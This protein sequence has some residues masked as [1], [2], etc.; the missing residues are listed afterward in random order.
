MPTMRRILLLLSVAIATTACGVVPFLPR[1][2]PIG[3]V[4]PG[5]APP[6]GGHGI[7]EGVTLADEG[8]T[9]V[10]EF[11]GGPPFDP[12]DPCSTAYVGWAAPDDADPG[13][14]HALVIDVTP[15]QVIP[16]GMGCDAV[17]HRRFVD[18]DLGGPFAGERVVDDTALREGTTWFLGPPAGLAMLPA[19]PDGWSL[20]REETL[21]ESPGGR[22]MRTFVAPGVGPDAPGPDG[23]LIVIQGFGQAADV[24]G[25]AEQRD[26]AVNGTPA[27]L[28][29][30]PDTGELVLVWRLGSD[31]MGLV[32]SE[33][34]FTAAALIR[35]AG[36]VHAP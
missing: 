27:V 24:T 19:V 32:A 36:D 13:L 33:S 12:N 6:P 25:G 14:L 20:A 35:F 34:D 17:G 5:A 4:P 16:N 15:P 23:R 1:P 26:V 7:I 31:G 30:E 9:L 22:W 21:P 28:S 18:V 11:T 2:V 29:R 3:Q 8:S 10:L